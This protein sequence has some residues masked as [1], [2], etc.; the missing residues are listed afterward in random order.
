MTDSTDFMTG[1]F[2]PSIS[3]FVLVSSLGPT[4]FVWFRAAFALAHVNIWCDI[5][6]YSVGGRESTLGMICETGWLVGWL[7][8]LTSLFSTNTAI[9]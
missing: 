9:S 7:V 1:P 2:L 8:G 4:L 6:S 5:V 3:V